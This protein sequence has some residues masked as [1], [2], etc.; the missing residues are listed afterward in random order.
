M[1]IFNTLLPYLFSTYADNKVFLKIA[2]K[3]P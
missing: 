1:Q 2:K 3:K